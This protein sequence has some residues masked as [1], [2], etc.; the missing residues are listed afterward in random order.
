M[1][2]LLVLTDKEN[3]MTGHELDS[4]ARIH[5]MFPET[6]RTSADYIWPTPPSEAWLNK[7]PDEAYKK[8]LKA[9]DDIHRRRLANEAQSCLQRKPL[10]EYAEHDLEDTK[11][12]ETG[13]P[14]C[15]LD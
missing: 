14:W 8:A 6:R 15:D 3:S 10:Y 12:P 13:A 7:Q 5:R 2:E 11:N 4:Q 1:K 9:I